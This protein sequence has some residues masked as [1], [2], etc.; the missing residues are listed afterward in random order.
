M[1]EDSERMQNSRI[2]ELQ[3]SVADWRNRCEEI[4]RE[5]ETLQRVNGEVRNLEI[6]I[7]EMSR[8]KQQ[9]Y[10]QVR[11]HNAVCGG[12]LRREEII[13]SGTGGLRIAILGV[14]LHFSNTGS[15]AM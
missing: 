1:T 4:G 2:E 14:W 10:E 13:F 9:L 8:D 12:S 5:N 6:A 7:E 11:Y 15:S 3:N